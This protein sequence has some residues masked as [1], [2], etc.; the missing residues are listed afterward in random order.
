[1][2]TIKLVIA[3]QGTRYDGWQSQRTGK[4]LQEVFEKQLAR[5]LT[6]KTNL[7]SSSRTDSGVHARGLVAH[8]KTKSHLPDAKLQ[9]ALNYYLPEDVLVLSAKTMPNDFHARYHAK[10]KTYEYLIWNSRTR[11]VYDLAPYCLWHGGDLDIPKMK[12]A[13]RVLVGKH[14][15]SAFRDSGDD[16]KDP[17]RTIYSI[18]IRK[19]GPTVS[20]L[21]RGN[22]FLRHMVR[23]VA[24][25][26]IQA[27][28]G[29]LT[30]EDIKSGL[31]SKNRKNTGPTSKAL[32]LTLL[33]V[34]Y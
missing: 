29:K 19:T 14:D 4:T 10:S 6:E 22:G 17:V 9:A 18:L 25:T 2:R 7:T 26:L 20:I 23:I 12:K 28:R 13:A 15:F 8:F 3:F 34:Q 24:G 11:P 16:E 30:I 32:G 31:A 33:K 21:V 5:I 27:G 1:M